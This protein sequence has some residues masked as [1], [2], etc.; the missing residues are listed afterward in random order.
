MTPSAAT[1]A[2]ARPVAADSAA[3][4]SLV[5]LL[6]ARCGDA[7]D[8]PAV[9]DGSQPAGAIS[10][11][12][13][14]SAAADLAAHYERSGLHRGDRLAHVGPQSIEWIVV[15]LAC[16][17]SGVVHVPLHADESRGVLR[18]QLGWLAA[19]GIVFSGGRPAL[20]ADDLPR[21]L[22]VIDPPALPA[23]N[24]SSPA[25]HRDALAARLE[26]HAA[27]CDPDAPATFF[28]SSG[29]TGHAH[30]V[31]H[32][33][34]ALAWN[35][36][37]ASAVF[38]DDPNDVRLA[39]LP[40]SH[41][42][43][44]T[45]D[46]Y[47]A[48]VRGSCLNLVRD[49]RRLLDTCRLAPPTVILGVPALFERLEQAVRTGSINDLPAAL[50]GRVRVCISG[51]AALRERTA[52]SFAEWGLPLVEGYGLAEAGPV[53][54]LANPRTMR[55]GFVGPALD[56]VELRIDARPESRGQLLVR[57][58]GRAIGIVTAGGA[59]DGR[60]PLAA[61]GWLETGD[62][63]EIDADGQVRI[64]GRIADGIVLATGQKIP[65][66][67]V[68]RAL[69]EDPAV[70]QACVLGDGLRWPVALVV[71]EPHVLRSAI[72]RMKLRV[73]SREQALRHPRVLAWLARRLARRQEKLPRGW[74]VR[75]ASL[76][77]RPFEAARGEATASLKL[78][79]R[80][81]AANFRHVLDAA[82]RQDT[83]AWMATIPVGQASSLPT[84]PSPACANAS[85][86]SCLWQ[87]QSHDGGFASSATT[88]AEPLRD[89]VTAILE[90][91][92]L[93]IEN[94]RAAD[95]LYDPPAEP[96]RLPAPPIDDAPPRQQGIFSATAE[97]ALGETGFWGLAVPESFGGAGCTMQELAR[98]ITR[99]AANVPT[100]AGML[101][102]HS[103]IGA[104]AALT[105][106]GSPDQQSRHLT[107]LARGLP[108]SIFGG[109]EP[110]AGCDLSAV[111]TKLERRDDS[112]L[113]TGTKMFI[114]GATHGRLVKLLA[115]LDGQPAV[116]LARLPDADDATFRLRRYP[117]HPL[118]HA[119]NAAL[120]FNGFKVEAAD[121]L[122]PPPDR[123]GRP[124]AMKII[125]HGL[126]RGR[127]TLAAQAAGTLRILLA[128]ARDFAGSRRTWGEPIGSRQ[129]VQG[130][131]GRIAARTLACDALAAWAAGCID[132]GETGE[133]EAITAKIVAGECVRES[134]IDAL[135]VHGGRAFLVGH[136]LGDSFHDHLAVTV[137]EG[138]SDLLGLALFKGLVKHHPLAS[139]ARD[140]AA[141][142]RAAVWLGWRIGRFARGPRPDAAILDPT[143][144]GHAALARR[145]LGRLALR[146][147]RT[148][149]RHGKQLA[150]RQLEIGCLSA[151][152]RDLVS[153][154]AVAHHADVAG[155]DSLLL[156]A[157][158]WCRIAL[159]RAHG[160]RLTASDHAQLA[161][162]GRTTP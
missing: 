2:R 109:T 43:A 55:P 51:G 132:A 5:E 7:F 54:T 127:I 82:A 40:M 34:R 78:K 67:E 71:P 102:V 135:G 129:L 8:R 11:G 159:A 116:A 142:R 114:T 105:A 89:T 113:L 126:N 145:S 92:E 61:D 96:S 87:T 57:T 50:G 122:I 44:R 29:T 147:D 128:Q 49:R 123:H 42:L 4:A 117:L 36:T 22:A 156:A 97:E 125:W 112:L 45:G 98:S 73:W 15:D 16:L 59:A 30:G 134:A 69:A 162:L 23:I 119:H 62:L 106:F 104:V 146:I 124:D 115:M 154:V 53:V 66:A 143:L 1:S 77:G 79:R 25:A 152:V 65:P 26:R 161:Q 133:L 41:G 155:D 131:L 14:I 33:Q 103:S 39:L 52:R 28:L 27:D 137:Y 157:D 86:A 83:P 81:I 63:A 138:E 120:E 84:Q 149:R 19:R 151:E 9:I 136:P 68:E 110:G 107:G 37:A 48:L 13:L 56:D 144:R 17:L 90:R 153:V 12:A 91:A 74:R 46:L 99:L 148:I 47:T 60:S 24:G 150:E 70:A 158:C 121:L 85:L 35:A 38:L 72:R 160:R 64:T 94:L 21:G 3:G 108:L 18:E 80:A 118:K 95:R 140:A 130:R 100:A 88:A 20:A 75:R 101:S 111:A 10:W 141:S 32:C 58:P 93:A 76:V 139:L 31:V 6:V